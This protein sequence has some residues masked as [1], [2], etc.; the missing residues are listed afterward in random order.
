MMIYITFDFDKFRNKNLC[1]NKVSKLKLNCTV[2]N[3]NEVYDIIL[4]ND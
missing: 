4:Y 2:Y 3:K 1:T